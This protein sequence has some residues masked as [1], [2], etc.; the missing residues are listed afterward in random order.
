MS[1]DFKV[2]EEN[3]MEFFAL[4]CCSEE[5]VNS[6]GLEVSPLKSKLQEKTEQSQQLQ[7]QILKQ[8]EALSRAS[9]TL[10]D[11]RKAAGN[12]CHQ[13]VERQTWWNHRRRVNQLQGKAMKSTSK[14]VSSSAELS[15]Y[16]SIILSLRHPR[17]LSVSNHRSSTAFSVSAPVK[18]LESAWYI[19]LSSSM[20]LCLGSTKKR[21]AEVEQV[22]MKLTLRSEEV[23]VDGLHENDQKAERL[24]K[25]GLRKIGLE[26]PT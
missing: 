16:L 25:R 1:D 23:S 17:S 3:E 11:T 2:G 9:Q 12:K 15:R 19:S 5:K 8:Q 4:P 18:F 21:G 13:Q 24:I 10:K 7:D 6:P 14:L 22:Y 26:E 20:F